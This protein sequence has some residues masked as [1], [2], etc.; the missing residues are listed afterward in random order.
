MVYCR[1][2]PGFSWPFQPLSKERAWVRVI[3][4]AEIHH[5]SFM[6]TVFQ[7]SEKRLQQTLSQIDYVL[8]DTP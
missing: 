6:N 7:K 5:M 4:F 8:T 3:E 2:K 1:T